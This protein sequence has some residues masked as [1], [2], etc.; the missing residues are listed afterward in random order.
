MKRPGQSLEPPE[1]Q[2]LEGDCYV[3]RICCPFS[4]VDQGC[5]KK[6]RQDRGN[7]RTLPR[8]T[9]PHFQRLSQRGMQPGAH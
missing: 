9:V 5:E 8:C 1:L 4:W 6:E 2:Y 3:Y 7:V